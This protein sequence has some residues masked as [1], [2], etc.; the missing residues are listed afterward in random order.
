MQLNGLTPFIFALVSGLLFFYLF[1]A[2]RRVS[3][4]WAVT[5][6]DR[7]ILDAKVARDE[8]A[9]LKRRSTAVE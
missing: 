5:D 9:Q 2:S 3:D 8:L 7:A 1:R 4:K 6:L